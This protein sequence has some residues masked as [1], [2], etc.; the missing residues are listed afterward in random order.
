[1]VG[2]FWYFGWLLLLAYLQ[3]LRRWVRLER[4]HGVPEKVPRLRPGIAF[5]A[6]L[7]IILMAGY[8]D[9]GFGDTWAYYKTFMDGPTTWEELL[10]YVAQ[11]QKDKGF[12]TTMALVRLMTSDARV[13][14]VLLATVQGLSL[15]YLFRRYSGNYLLCL[16]LFVASTDMHSWM[17]NGIRQFTAV[18]IILL[19]TPFYLKKQYGKGILVILFA[20]LFHQSALLMIPFLFIVQG[21]AWNKKTVAF[22]VG[23]IVIVSFVEEFTGLLD[24]SLKDTQYGNVVSDYTSWND[25]GTNPIRVLVYSVPAIMAFFGRSVIQKEG[26]K[27]IHFCANM[28]VVSAGLYLISMFT[29]GIFMGRLPIYF[30]L[31]GYILLPWEIEHFF[32]KKSQGFVKKMMIVLY[33]GFYCYQMFYTW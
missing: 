24:S 18:A 25:D 8:R 32:V 7:P 31:Y 12:Y 4:V 22:I 27:L 9:F 10:A 2:Y 28:S 19:G 30:S 16:F 5:V 14:F 3:P 15:M 21:N 11:L 33:L 1:M 13:F 29:S 17:Y 6:I 23:A 26:N 20:S